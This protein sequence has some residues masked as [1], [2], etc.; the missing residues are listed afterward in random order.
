[1]RLVFKRKHQ[2]KYTV[3]EYNFCF[4]R[5]VLTSSQK[6]CA[7]AAFE[8][9]TSRQKIFLRFILRITART[10]SAQFLARTYLIRGSCVIRD[11]YQGYPEL[12]MAKYDTIRILYGSMKFITGTRS[13]T[14]NRKRISRQVAFAKRWNLKCESFVPL[15]TEQETS[16]QATTVQMKLLFFPPRAEDAM[17]F[18]GL[19][20]GKHANI[21]SSRI[22]NKN[23]NFIA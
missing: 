18:L 16:T 22:E 1:M 17:Q 11:G 4:R 20:T 5:N 9:R 13:R 23:G 12:R 6:I 15:N 8:T 19:S 7:V 2:S 10:Q 3:Q 21:F 14:E